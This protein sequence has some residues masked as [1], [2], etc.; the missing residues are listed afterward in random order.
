MMIDR[1]EALPA[2]ES[3]AIKAEDLRVLWGLNSDRA[4]RQAVHSMRRNGLIVCSGNA[5]Y[6]R[7][8][9]MDEVKRTVKRLH[10]QAKATFVAAQGAAKTIRQ[11]GLE[12]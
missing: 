6:W 2:G 10:G 3:W 9:T 8:E 5:G 11:A 4:V 12:G 7:P 1:Y